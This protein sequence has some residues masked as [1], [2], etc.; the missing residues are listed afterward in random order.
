VYGQYLTYLL[1][2]LPLGWL[3][4]SSLVHRDHTQQRSQTA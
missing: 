2:L 1:V 3:V 4:V